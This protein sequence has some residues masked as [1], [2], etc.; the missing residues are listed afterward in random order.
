MTELRSIRRVSQKR[1]HESTSRFPPLAPTGCCSPTSSVLSR[2]YDALLPSCHA[3]FPRLAVPRVALVSF[4]PRRTSAPP[5]PGVRN[6]VA[7]VR[8]FAEERTGFSQVPGEPPLSVCNVPA[9]PAGLLAPDHYGAAAWPLVIERQRLPR[10][11][12]RRSG[13]IAF[14]LAVYASQCGLLQPHAR[15]ASSCW[16]SST[17]RAFHPHGLPLKGFRFVSYISFPSPKLSWRNRCD[18]RRLAAAVVAS[19]SDESDWR[20]DCTT[21]RKSVHSRAWI[22]P[23]NGVLPSKGSNRWNYRFA[24]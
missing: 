11:V 9:T 1:F 2:R 4:A 16:S 7:P 21:T 3:S 5:R 20:R 24:G 6:P 10:K 8:K 17:G 19:P 15:L 14:R 13:S 23:C 18:R 12:F 22:T